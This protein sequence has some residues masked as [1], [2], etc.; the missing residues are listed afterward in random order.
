MLERQERSL[1]VLKAELGGECAKRHLDEAAIKRKLKAVKKQKGQV[2]RQKKEL[3]KAQADY[4]KV[5]DLFDWEAY[6]KRPIEIGNMV[7]IKNGR[8]AG[9]V[10]E[11]IKRTKKYRFA[12]RVLSADYEIIYQK[13]KN[14]EK[15]DDV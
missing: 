8:Y 7:M 13:A 1:E 9:E 5:R 15:S 14:L 3:R 4:E 12:V 10:G 6:F 11:V 2:K